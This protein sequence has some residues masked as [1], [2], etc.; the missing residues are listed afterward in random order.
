MIIG[1]KSTGRCKELESA[2]TCSGALDYET[3]NFFFG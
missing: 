1:A 2:R 3:L